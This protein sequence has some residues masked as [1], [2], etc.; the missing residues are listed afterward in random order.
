VEFRLELGGAR[1][2][3]SERIELNGQVS[4]SLDRADQRPGTGRFSQEG[5]ITPLA[6]AT[7]PSCSA[8]PEELT[9]RLVDGEWVAPIPLEGLG[10][11]AVVENARHG[12]ATHK[13]QKSNRALDLKSL[14]ARGSHL[15]PRQHQCER[16]PLPRLR[17]HVNSSAQHLGQSSRDVEAEAGATVTACEARVE[18]ANG[19]K[20]RSRSC[21]AMPIPVSLTMNATS[22]FRASRRRHTSPRSVNFTALPA[23]FTRI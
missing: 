12:K 4:V 18:L 9:P 1:R 2:R 22:P 20:S 3:R 17:L 13:R 21:F 23:R 6:G 14:T 5:G 10:D 19:W 7:P 8:S 11:E 16:R 15:F